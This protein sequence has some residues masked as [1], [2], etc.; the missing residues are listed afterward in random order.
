MKVF[1]MTKF[2]LKNP[3]FAKTAVFSFKMSDLEIFT[4][5][6]QAPNTSDI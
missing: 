4:W 1:S 2:L 5:L 3:S 6:T